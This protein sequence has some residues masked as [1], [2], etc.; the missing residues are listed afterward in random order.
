MTLLMLAIQLVID[1]PRPVD[2]ALSELAQKHG[3][4]VSYEDPFYFYAADTERV[5]GV[6][7]P[8]P[9]RAHFSAAC[10]PDDALSAARAVV[11]AANRQL[12]FRFVLDDT[13]ERLAVIATK[14]R[15]ADGR[16]IDMT[17]L[18][19]RKVTI[20]AG[21][22]AVHEHARLLAES[23]SAQTGF[24]VSCCQSVIGGVP[25][26]MQVVAF[27]ADGESARRVLRR[28]MGIAG[29]SRYTQACDPVAPRR[30]TWC[31]IEVDVTS[32]GKL[33]HRE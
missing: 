1:A 10:S 3:I 11:D 12:P 7:F 2:A 17:P 25:W 18:L 29:G 33:H 21:T 31:F 22:R 6:R 27:A 15:S 19:D 24:H 20:P 8:V 5:V 16:T 28:L 32:A 23:L 26:G 9:R 30:P 4:A 14:T 13:P